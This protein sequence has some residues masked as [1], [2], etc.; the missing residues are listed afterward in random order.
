MILNDFRAKEP[1]A[2]VV[3][4]RPRVGLCCRNAAIISAFSP[5]FGCAQI[6]AQIVSWLI[7]RVGSSGCMDLSLHVICSEGQR[8]CPRPD[9][10]THRLVGR[11]PHP[12]RRQLSRPV[13]LC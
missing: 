5:P 1:P 8:R 6:A 3:R 9:Q 7:R 12:D 4:E 11:I 2:S 10:I 13:Q